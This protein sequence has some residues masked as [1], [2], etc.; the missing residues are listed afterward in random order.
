[1]TAKNDLSLA[2]V[3]IP[4]L[5]TAHP[6][7]AEHLARAE[8]AARAAGLLETEQDVDRFRAFAKID[9]YFFHYATLDRLSAAASYSEWMYFLDDSY[10]DHP[11][12]A[13]DVDAVE[14]QL[15]R[16]FEVMRTGELPS[17]ATPLERFTR[18][19][20]QSLRAAAPSDA[21]FAL[22]LERCRDYMFH[23]S[24]RSMEF[25][26]QGGPPSVAA[27]AEVR[28]HDSGVLPVLACSL[29]A[30]NTE[31]PPEVLAHPSVVALERHTVRHVAFLNDLFSYQK[32]VLRHGYP[33]NLVHAIATE[34]RLDLAAAAKVAIET[35]NE[36]LRAFVALERSLPHFSAELDAGLARYVVGMKALMRG[37]YDFSLKSRRFRD[38]ESPFREL[39]RTRTISFEMPAVVVPSP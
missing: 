4:W 27:Y 39:R 9:L 31:L 28:S 33:C 21:W 17:Q 10:D 34:Q 2:A 37:N 8:A 23:G 5:R 16:A 18:H 12:Y 22:F 36:E 24:L 25:W 1:M 6:E 30:S 38:A 35:V 7:A 19:V 3:E 11:G 29:L 13:N 26:K 14:R 20:H 15:L 32:E